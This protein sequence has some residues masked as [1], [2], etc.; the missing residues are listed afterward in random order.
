MSHSHPHLA[1]ANLL[2]PSIAHTSESLELL[3][4]ARSVSTVTRF[5]P[6]PTGFLHIG[7]VYT[8]LLSERIAHLN[9]GIF[10]LRVE[11]TDDKREIENGVY[12]ITEGL[13]KFGIT[14]DE[15]PIG[16]DGADVGSY[17]PYTQSKRGSIYQT[18]VKELV[19]RGMAYPCFLSESESVAI[20]E[21]QT[22]AKQPLGIYGSYSPWRV[23]TLEEVTE[24]LSAGKKYVLRFRAHGNPNK[25]AK[26]HDEI[27]GDIEMQDNFMDTVLLKQTGI[28]TYHLAHVVDDHLM[29]T[30]HVIRAEEWIPSFALHIQLTEALGFQA[31]KY[32][33]I[34]PLLKADGGG[35][36]KLSKRKDPEANVE[37]FFEQGYTVEALVDYMLGI[38]DS[39]YEAW[40]LENPTVN[41]KTYPLV[42]DRLPLSGA[43]FDIVKLDSI[44]NTVLTRLS[45]EELQ[46][47]GLEWA[48]K[49]DKE[50]AR[51]M[52]Q[53]PEMTYKALDIERHT[54]KDPRRFTKFSD[55]RGQLQFFYEE[56]FESLKNTA[57]SLPECV[58]PEV[59]KAFIEDYLKA[60]D[61]TMDRDV[62]FEQLKNIAHTHKF[63]R[64][65]DEWKTGEYIGRVGDIAMMLRLLLCA[66]AKTPDL[67]YTMRVLGRETMEKRLKR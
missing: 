26:L 53:Y 21:E 14:I 31:P 5:G 25:R 46:S 65:G 36:R 64:T 44:A 13:A 17:G 30:T 50:L 7:G 19:A 35:K 38:M 29:R 4:P 27:R 33:H 59:Q 51:L 8:S 42:I 6:S 12:M 54:E 49:Y 20:R 34:A 58:T 62:W 11:D 23:A 66:S 16:K 22:L 15:G 28:P 48:Q 55:L 2:F 37:F 41:Y 9:S 40:R 24:A 39:K 45:T 60:Y 57:P 52:E 32:I 63:A 10:Y 56:T 18:Y 67:C 3:Y 47:Q 43:L 61:S 1:L